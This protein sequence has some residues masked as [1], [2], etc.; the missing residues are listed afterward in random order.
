MWTALPPSDYYGSSAPSWRHRPATGLPAGQ[1]GAGRGGDR[2]GGSHVH[3]R[4]DR[5]VRCPTMPLRHRHGY[6]A[7]IHRGLPVGDIDRP[8]SS[9]PNPLVPL[10]AATQ[11]SVRLQ[12]VVSSLG[13][14]V[15]WFTV[16]TPSRLACR[17]RDHLTVLARPG[18]VEAACRRRPR[19][20]ALAALSFP[21]PLRRAG[22]G[23]L[24]PPL[25]S[26]APRGALYPSSSTG[27]AGPP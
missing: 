14:F 15:R 5:R 24:A 9:W 17:T 25:G 3:S 6:A 22:G 7:G 23:V 12:L 18:F 16:V 21:R 1:R 2:Q 4:T 10:R 19:P 20:R 27:S 26:R 8:R 11:P 13:A